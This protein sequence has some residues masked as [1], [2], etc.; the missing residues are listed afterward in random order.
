MVNFKISL[1]ATVSNF[2]WKVTGWS[3]NPLKNTYKYIV[4]VL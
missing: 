4:I 3:L 2:K 1:Q